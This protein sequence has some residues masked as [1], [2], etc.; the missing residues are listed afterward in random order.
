MEY[1]YLIICF[2][3]SICITPLVKKLALRYKVTD[4]PNHR[5]VHNKVMPRLGGL[6]IYLSFIIGL[7]IS[8]QDSPFLWPIIIG[9]T[10][11][12]ITGILDDKFNLSPRY[13]LIGQFLAAI[14]AIRGG[15]DLE[16]INLPFG[17]K[18]EF[19]YFIVP[20]TI[21]WIIGITNAINLIDGLDGLAAGVSAIAL[22][23]LSIMA[24]IQQDIFVLTIALILLGS[25]LGFLPFNFYPAK[26]FMG[27]SGALFLGY[28][29]AVLSLLGFKNVTFFSFVIPI[30]ILGVP[31]SD[32]IFAIIRRIINNQPIS[33]PDRSHLHHRLLGSGF[34]HRQSVLVIYGIAVMFSLAAVVFSMATV[35]G[36]LIIIVVLL[37]AIELFVEVM[38]LVGKDYKPLLKFMRPKP[39]SRYN[40]RI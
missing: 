4:K 1:L 13:K 30:I 29:I 22:I 35:W 25:T 20:I 39:S 16:F 34:S 10:I 17:G 26:I 7:I 40:D 14:V 33:S 3:A 12:V 31:I 9:S 11:I 18:L 6:A 21:L 36:S 23:T 38:G 32:T 24:F 15:F 2:V 37:F 8:R 19:G 27:D 28:M 5:K